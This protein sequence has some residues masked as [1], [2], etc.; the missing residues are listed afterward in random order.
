MEG[1]CTIWLEMNRHD[2]RTKVTLTRGSLTRSDQLW[3][4]HHK[5]VFN[6]GSKEKYIPYHVLSNETLFRT[7]R[8]VHEQYHYCRIHLVFINKKKSSK[9]LQSSREKDEVKYNCKIPCTDVS[10]GISPKRKC[11]R[12]LTYYWHNYSPRS[13]CV[14]DVWKCIDHLVLNTDLQGPTL[15]Q[16]DIALEDLAWTPQF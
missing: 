2:I 16:L 4:L 14:S 6:S 15:W 1:E 8:K 13:H 11:S 5:A 7:L 12:R 3:P 10:T 9:W